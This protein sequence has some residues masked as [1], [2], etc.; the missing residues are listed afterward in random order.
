MR[1]LRRKADEITAMVTVSDTRARAA[2]E[3]ELPVRTLGELY[4]VCREAAGAGLVEVTLDGPEGTVALH[5]GSLVKDPSRPPRKPAR[6]HL[7]GR[8]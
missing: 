8:R 2:V 7:L 4:K 5:F 6:R 1:L 3:S